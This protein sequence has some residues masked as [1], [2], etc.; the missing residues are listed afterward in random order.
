MKKIVSVRNVLVG[1]GQISIQ[2]MTNLPVTDVAATIEQIN[3]LQAAGCDIVRIAVPNADSVKAFAEVRKQTDMPLVADIH[4]DYRLAVAACDAGAD[5]I[6]INPGN[7]GENH[8]AEVVVA[9]R[10]NGV[11]VRIG[12][13]GGS[14]N[15]DTY[16]FFCDKAAKDPDSIPS[17]DPLFDLSS[18]VKV[19]ALCESVKNY[20]DMFDKLGFDDLVLSVKSSNVRETIAANKLLGKLGFPLHLGVTEAGLLRQGIVKNA[21]GI[22]ALLLQGI[23]DT[24][25]V[26]LTADPVEE[27]YAARDLLVSLGLRKGVT[28]ISCPKCGRCT[29]DLQGVA[30]QV[31]KYVSPLDSDIKVAVMGCEVNGPGECSDAD[32]GMAGAKGGFVFFK[33]GCVY[34]RVAADV[35][36]T[37]FTKEVDEIVAKNR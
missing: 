11:P 37:E 10:A 1:N 28:F 36:V 4:F 27:V 24:I 22:G 8:L 5:K 3:K 20:I 9:A 15:K 33:Q 7:I 14:P 30:E 18:N 17:L 21:V 19:L 31:Y 16:A 29:V 26:S 12:V 34:K 2:S 23:G 25:R 6:R 32:I 13:N 35:A